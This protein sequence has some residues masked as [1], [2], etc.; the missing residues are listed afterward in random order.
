MIIW[1]YVAIFL[2]VLVCSILVIKIYIMKKSFKSIVALLDNILK[3][4]TNNLITV[5]SS[6]K[7]IKNLVI[8]LNNELDIFRKQKLQYQNGNQEL[9]KNITNISH[10]L[11]T[12]LTAINGYIDLL[13]K[14][15]ALPSQKRALDILKKKSVELAELTE[16]LFDF[17]KIMD[18]DICLDMDNFVINEILEETLL[19]FYT[20]FKEKGIVPDVVICEEKVCRVI[21]K[22]SIIRVFENILSNVLKYGEGDF[23]VELHK[24][25]K[26]V[27]SNK[28]SF[29][30][31]TS[32]QKIFDRY[33]TVENG[34]PAN[35]IGLSIAK[36]LVELNHGKIDAKYFDG[37]LVIEV[38]L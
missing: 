25:G 5:T 7:D 2:L 38:M 12:P 37:C 24:D 20:V 16:Q 1:L 6:D 11:I 32:A 31:S 22:V 19:G 21:N 33:F 29:L 9:K 23:H 3:S 15:N 18:L 26:I 30:D 8:S 14:E 28:A 27:F 13:Q 4:D 10:D 34:K 17:S 36:Q 35:G